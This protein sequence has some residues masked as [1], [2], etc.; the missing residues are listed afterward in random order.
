M[1]DATDHFLEGLEQVAR[2][3]IQIRCARG[4]M[5]DALGNSMQD[6]RGRKDRGGGETRHAMQSLAP[7]PKVTCPQGDR[8]VTASDTS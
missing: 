6:R 3:S 1:N 7:Q 8:D 2:S 5:E 4:Q